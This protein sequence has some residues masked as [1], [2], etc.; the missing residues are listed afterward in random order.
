[1]RVAD[2][3]VTPLAKQR[4]TDTTAGAHAADDALVFRDAVRD[5]KPLVQPARAGGLDKPRPHPRRR[6]RGSARAAGELDE[7]MPLLADAS[8][9]DDAIG[10]ADALSFRRPG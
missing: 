1:M 6:T 7:I 8:P 9:A 10:G 2:R 5:V 4:S 3:V